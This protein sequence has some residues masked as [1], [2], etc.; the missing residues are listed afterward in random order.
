[1]A[2][3]DGAVL[4]LSSDLASSQV[5]PM[6]D[7]SYGGQFGWSPNQAEWISNQ[8]YVRRPL[9]CILLE[10]PGFFQAMPNPP[11]WVQTL[12]SLVELHPR[13]IEGLKADLTVDTD[14][15][16]AGG[17]GEMMQE[18]I[19]VKRARSEIAF[20]FVEK[21][22]MPISNFLYSWITYGMMDPDTKV[23]MLATI[24][25]AVQAQS[26]GT[27]LNGS[28]V[29][30]DLLA[31]WYSMS[32]LFFEPDPI[33]TNV[34]KAWVATNMWPKGTGTIEGKRDLT[35]PGELNTL[36]IEFTSIC[37]YNLGTKLFAQSILDQI[38]I[39]NANPNLRPSFIQPGA[40][41]NA[42]GG[43][44]Y[45]YGAAALASNAVSTTMGQTNV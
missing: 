39:V 16:P 37:Q 11:L 40:D 36:N 3:I 15:H 35:T 18:F 26:L 14:E 12:K 1:M 2:R 23:S 42:D 4:D 19:D 6:L 45:Q 5:A 7:I 22:G 25:G 29:A 21:Y 17:A 33:H 32:C 44:G 31:D 10:A 27:P 20:T 30:G 8:A 24:S 41:A 13:S 34:L 28:Q 43:M 9:V 38:N